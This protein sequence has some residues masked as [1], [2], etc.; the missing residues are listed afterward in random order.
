MLKEKL[1]VKRKVKKAKRKILKK[2]F[3]EKNIKFVV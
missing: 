2:C 3:E 1:D